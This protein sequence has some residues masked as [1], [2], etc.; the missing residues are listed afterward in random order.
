MTISLQ[1]FLYI[2]Y[3]FLA[4][5]AIFVFFN[6]Y[7]LLKFSFLTFKSILLTGVF[8]SGTIVLLFLSFAFI[9]EIDWTQSFT[10][11]EMPKGGTRF[12][13]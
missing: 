13:P 8:V 6:I 3:A 7:H 12:L 9:N 1:F 4:V 11:F 10:I 2:Y 5:Y